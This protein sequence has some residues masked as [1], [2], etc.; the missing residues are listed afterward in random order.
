[1]RSNGEVGIV[2]LRAMTAGETLDAAVA[3]LRQRALPLIPVALV[4]AAGEQIL[5]FGLRAYS[6]MEPPFYYLPPRLSEPS[7]WPVI[8]LGFAV[9]AFI[10]ALLAAY[11]GAA[12]GPALLGRAVGHLALF[13]RIRPVPAVAIALLVAVLSGTAALAGLVLW[14]LVYGVTALATAVLTVDRPANPLTAVARAAGRATRGGMRGVG[15]LI[16]GYLTWAVVRTALGSG[17]IAVADLFQSVS[18]ASWLVWA[19]PVAWTLA[20]AV[21]YAALACLNAVL[22]LEIRIRTEGLDIAV[23]RARSRG[24]DPAAALVVKR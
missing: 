3:L 18:G 21:A 5:L 8:G 23:N 10:I 19:V 12:A 24:T 14:P 11:A 16:L 22:L 4:L 20:N 7:W 2:A 17:W 6:G 1:M 9:E 13:K 15:V